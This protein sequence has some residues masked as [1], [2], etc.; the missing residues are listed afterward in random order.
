ME[1][2]GKSIA[3][4]GATGFLG[5]Y[6]V[7][8]LLQR[9]AHVVGVV[10]T[11]DRVPELLER[12]VEMRK[13][14]LADQ[15]AL[16][17]GFKGVDAIVSNAALFAVGNLDWQAH[18]DANVD[19]TRNVMQAASAAGVKRIVHVSSVAVYRKH[20]QP[21]SDETQPMLERRNLKR[22]NAYQVS[23]AL[24]EQL[25]WELAE[26]LK[27]DLSCARPSA[28]Y[29]AFDPNFMRL[30]RKFLGFPAA[31]I[32]VG[33]RVGIVYGGDVAEGVAKMLENDGSIG[34][35]YNLTG[36]DASVWSFW[37]AWKKAD[38]RAPSV[39]VPVPVPVRQLWDNSRAE[40]ELGWSNRSFL[41]GLRETV[42]LESGA[43]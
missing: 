15:Q 31:P 36:P 43:G 37:Q 17:D 19:G 35:S 33:L 22:F 1:L 24:S 16:V 25:A 3:V 18:V 40:Q 6:I 28:I 7:D 13:A 34:K 32:P 10:R 41:D 2:K 5:R 26:E 20:A 39:A 30:V 23:K 38:P 27:L 21:L 12:G 42:E 4:T 9:G 11:P 29:G 14:D 8:S